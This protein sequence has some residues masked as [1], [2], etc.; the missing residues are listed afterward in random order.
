[1]RRYFLQQWP[2]LCYFACDGDEP[3]GVVVGKLE[4]HK[5]TGAMR[6]YIGML[7]VTKPHRGLGVGARPRKVVA[8]SPMHAAFMEVAATATGNGGS[9]GA[10]A[11]SVCTICLCKLAEV[12]ASLWPQIR[13]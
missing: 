3:F 12:P 9:H 8:V 1:M 13:M 7:V 4:P 6:G 5:S 2:E 10:Q 11:M